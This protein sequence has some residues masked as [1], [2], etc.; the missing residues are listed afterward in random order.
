[1]LYATT[2]SDVVVVLYTCTTGRE[3]KR[4]KEKERETKRK[5]ERQRER[6]RKKERQ[7]ETKRKKV[8]K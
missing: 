4:D 5:K 1:M 2:T 3:T 8:R 7:R 6:K